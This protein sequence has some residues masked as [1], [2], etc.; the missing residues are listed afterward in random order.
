MAVHMNVYFSL[1]FFVKNIKAIIDVI[2]DIQNLNVDEILIEYKV[3]K[4]ILSL[5]DIKNKQTNFM[6][7][8]P[9]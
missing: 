3:P 5:I 4:S 7:V 1:D 2:Q 6:S 9:K 8:Q